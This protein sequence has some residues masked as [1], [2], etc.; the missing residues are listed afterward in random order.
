MYVFNLEM[1][2]T[3]VPFNKLKQMA[4]FL[5]MASKIGFSGLGPDFGANGIKGNGFGCAKLSK[6]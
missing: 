3:S 2:R 6:Q 4:L 1:R 5:L